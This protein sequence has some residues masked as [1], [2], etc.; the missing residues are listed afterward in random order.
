MIEYGILESTFYIKFSLLLY[1]YKKKAK[2]ISSIKYK[3][4]EALIWNVFCWSENAF[5]F[6][7]RAGHVA[8]FN[9]CWCWHCHHKPLLI[10]HWYWKQQSYRN[11][12]WLITC[13]PK[14]NISTWST[15]KIYCCYH[16]R[17]RINLNSNVDLL[18]FFSHFLFNSLLSCSLPYVYLILLWQLSFASRVCDLQQLNENI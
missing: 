11:H 6:E 9:S 16:N 1:Y 3:F 14:V 10:K 17:T 8:I 2:L 5:A 7:Y 18:R 13:N 4:A 15:S 12:I